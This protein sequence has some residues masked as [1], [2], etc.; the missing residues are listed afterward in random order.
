MAVFVV[1][2]WEGKI[3]RA[4]TIFSFLDEF[5]P[6]KAIFIRR[7]CQITF[8]PILELTRYCVVGSSYNFN[9]GFGRFLQ[10]TYRL[11]HFFVLL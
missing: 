8:I 1:G 10:V 3:E 5:G 2:K 7:K 4:K 6:P 9:F 11:F